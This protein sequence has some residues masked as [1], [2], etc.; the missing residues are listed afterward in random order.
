[1]TTRQE[2]ERS[3][4]T[5]TANGEILRQGQQIGWLFEREPA[6]R[7]VPLGRPRKTEPMG[8]EECRADRYEVPR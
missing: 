2:L 5:V 3:G 1:M 7:P 6:L 4:C 8:D